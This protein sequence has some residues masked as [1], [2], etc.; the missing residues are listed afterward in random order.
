MAWTYSGDP[1]TSDRDF[2]RFTIGDNIEAEPILQDK[3]IDFIVAKYSDENE[4]LYNLYDFAATFFARHVSRKLGPQSEFTSD[5]QKHFE[6]K[7]EYYRKRLQVTF[8][9]TLPKSSEAIFN[10]G[11]HDNV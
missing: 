2:Y 11:M 7:A 10:K 1:A 3:E 9:I 5:R 6:D 8:G 4:R